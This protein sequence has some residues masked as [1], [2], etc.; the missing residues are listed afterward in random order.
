MRCFLKQNLRRIVIP[1]ALLVIFATP[2]RSG[3]FSKSDRELANAML[4]NAA[5]DVRKHY[6]DPKFH[7][8]DWDARVQGAKTK[9]EAA[10]SL[11]VAMSE[12]ANLLATLNDSHTY[13]FPP[14]LSHVHDYGFQIEMIGQQC[15]VVRVRHG[16]D[17]EKKGLKPGDE[18]QAINEN[19]VSRQNFAKL[20]YILN[21]LRPQTSLR[22]ALAGEAGHT[23]QVEVITSFKLSPVNQYFTMQGSNYARRDAQDELRLLRARYFEKGKD[24]LVVKIPAFAFS[25]SGVDDIIA[26]MRPHQ[27]VILDLRGNPGGYLLTLDY[28]LGGIFDNDLKI[29]DRVE[30][31]STKPI[32]VK[33]RHQS[34]FTGRFA[35]LIDSESASA[36]EVLARVIQLQKRGTVIGDRSLGRAMEAKRYLHQVEFHSR[37]S[38]GISVTQADMVMTDGSSLE[39]LGV[40]P[41]VLVLPTPADLA[42]QRD[43]VLA[44]AAELLG[45]QISPEEA[46]KILPY[47]ENEQFDTPLSLND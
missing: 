46:G 33:G 38:Y 30:R 15:Y 39:H 1:T 11:N 31:E 36:S 7:G 13:F 21:V 5:E 3:Q 19:P 10:T 47:Q 14:P 37:F 26:K 16:S 8:V 28:L 22:L 40:A 20:I 9:V 42:S 25:Q 18:V 24:L 45:V 35:V 29:Y 2:S 4:Q 43:P 17:A 23:R 34:A 27:G 12:I 32:S 44:K 6:Y 41:D